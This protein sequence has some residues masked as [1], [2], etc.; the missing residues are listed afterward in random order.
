MKHLTAIGIS[1]LSAAL[2][3]GPAEKLDPVS[4][5]YPDWQGVT[6]NGYICGR[7]IGPSD[8]RH[9]VTIVVEVEAN[10]KLKEQLMLAGPLVTYSSLNGVSTEGL[11]WDTL[12]LPRD[13]I[14]VVS[15]HGAKKRSVVTD[16]WEKKELKEEEAALLRGC[17]QLGTSVYDDVT[18]TGAPDN[19]GKYPFVYVMGP[20]AGKEP[21]YKGEL[22]EASAK[23]AIAVVN[24]AKRQIAGWDQKWQPFYGNVGVPKYNTSLVKALE[25]GK[26]ARKCPL[27]SVQKGLLADI[28]SAD[29]ERSKEAQILFDAI[30]QTRSDLLIRI[31]YE[32]GERPHCAYYDLQT[33]FKYWPNTP[34]KA[35]DAV[36]TR[37]KA[38]PLAESLGKIYV[39]LKL[40][41]DPSFTC[42]N[43]S[44]AKKIVA[45]L[46]KMKKQLAPH[47][48]SQNINIQN[49]ALLLDSKIDTV[50]ELIQSKVESK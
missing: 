14:A 37:M 38:Y 15:V 13:V 49:G 23:E 43:A 39:K 31:R 4:E 19:G 44:E 40:W 24:K 45:E 18:F 25:K 47:K 34:K 8:L 12:D 1:F 50:T 3:A 22:T 9:K 10:E 46:K 20:G 41:S 27:D 16:I 6:P 2:L 17:R 21:L 29:E 7:E 35:L 11:D 42:K 28:K 26:T 48:E 32:V 5:F 30:N 33:L 36:M